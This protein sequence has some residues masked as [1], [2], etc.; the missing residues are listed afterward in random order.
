VWT[1]TENRI[2]QMDTIADHWTPSGRHGRER[3]K[4]W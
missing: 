4:T 3:S 1:Y 2:E